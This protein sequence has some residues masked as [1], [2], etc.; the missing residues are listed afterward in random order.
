MEEQTERKYGEEE[1][2]Y[3][4][5]RIREVHEVLMELARLK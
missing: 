3:T 1:P 2:L 5:L 4:S